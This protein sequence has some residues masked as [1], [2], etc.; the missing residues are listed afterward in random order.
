[1]LRRSDSD[2]VVNAAR[3]AVVD[4]LDHVAPDLSD[5][6]RNLARAATHAL[7]AR[8]EGHLLIEIGVDIVIDAMGTPWIIEVNSRPRGRLEAVASADPDGWQH[9]HVAACARPLRYLAGR[10][11]R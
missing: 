10:F 8:P 4:P 3:G 11:E 7:A 1:V 2:P 9:A 5:P 6:V